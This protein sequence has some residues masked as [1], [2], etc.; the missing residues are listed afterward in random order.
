[1]DARRGELGEVSEL[2]VVAGMRARCEPSVLVAG[3]ILQQP[4]AP[5]LREHITFAELGA[6]VRAVELVQ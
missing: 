3:R 1:M 4:Q 5:E 2:A 6:R